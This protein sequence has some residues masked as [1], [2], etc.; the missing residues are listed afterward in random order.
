M[1]ATVDLRTGNYRVLNR[2]ETADS[3][4]RG[5]DSDP[6]DLMGEDV[7]VVVRGQTIT[8]LDPSTGDVLWTKHM[9]EFTVAP[10]DGGIL[11]L[12]SNESHNPFLPVFAGSS[13]SIRMVLLSP[14]SG[15]QIA[16]AVGPDG[17]YFPNYPHREIGA[18]YAVIAPSNG[19]PYVIR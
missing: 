18:A 2:E 13:D 7:E 10:V 5:S 3:G 15:R 19:A 12:Q 14:G 1:L 11:L 6:Q 17:G 4:N 9:S 8:G 16:S